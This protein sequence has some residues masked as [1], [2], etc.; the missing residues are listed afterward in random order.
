MYVDRKFVA[1]EPRGAE[2]RHGPL[3]HRLF[4]HSDNA[5]PRLAAKRANPHGNPITLPSPPKK[6]RGFEKWIRG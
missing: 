5:E 1:A 6:K 4:V 2:M 3:D